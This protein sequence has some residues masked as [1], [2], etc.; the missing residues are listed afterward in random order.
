MLKTLSLCGLFTLL[1][2]YFQHNPC[3]LDIKSSFPSLV[4]EALCCLWPSVPCEQKA[5]R[6]PSLSPPP[7]TRTCFSNGEER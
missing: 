3:Q 1:K 2:Y 5:S 7:S 6:R 4:F